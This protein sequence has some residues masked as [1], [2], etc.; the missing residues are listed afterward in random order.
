MSHKEYVKKLRTYLPAEAFLPATT[1]L[2]WVA[3]HL[4]IILTC[5]SLI[6]FKSSILL[7]L[8][9]AMI[10]GQS[11]VCIGFLAHELSHGAI[12]RNRMLRYTL[13]V[14]LWGMS[15]IPATIWRRVHNQTHHIHANTPLDPDRP[16]LPSEESASTKLYSKLFYP[17]RS[18]IRINP[19]VAF[20]LS[21]YIIRNTVASFC[22]E[23]KKPRIVPACP[24]YSLAQ[25]CATVGEIG[26]ILL[27]QVIVFYLVGSSWQNWIWASV[28]SY[29]FASGLVMSYI[30][31]NHFLNPIS[32]SH[33]PLAHTT[34]VVVPAWMDRLHQHFSLHT[35]HHL[36]PSINSDYYPAVAEALKKEFPERYNVLP[37]AEAWR[38]LWRQK[39]FSPAVET[40]D[41]PT[42]RSK[43]P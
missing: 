22:S 13:E 31:T 26:F 37:M 42:H 12:L 25:R 5:Y 39:Y 40:V 16:F 15:F 9:F 18:A 28:V 38:R 20:H 8:L 29:V 32:E 14:F 24:C 10:I 4:A 2:F 3:L 34:S 27:W 23:R 41:D 19:L 11:L 21:G 35:E 17:Q 43:Q 1:K 6:R 7:C 36:F 30:F 33:D